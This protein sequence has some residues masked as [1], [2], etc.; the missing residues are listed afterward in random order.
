MSGPVRLVAPGHTRDGMLFRANMQRFAAWL[1]TSGALVLDPGSEFEAARWRCRVSTDEPDDKVRTCIVWRDKQGAFKFDE[2]AMRHWNL[3]VAGM[4]MPKQ[5]DQI[6][7]PKKVKSWTQRRREEL[8]ERDG[9]NCYYCGKTMIGHDHNG[10]PMPEGKDDITIE[11]LLSLHNK[12][13]EAAKGVDVNHID[14]LVLAHRVCN[15][16]IGHRPVHEKLMYREIAHD[17]TS[18]VKHWKD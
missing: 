2:D 4:E 5:P 6:A 13:E 11:H 7:V 17:Q 18:D 10:R 1:A 14:Y 3:F 9:T 8:I 12:E 15:R 16:L